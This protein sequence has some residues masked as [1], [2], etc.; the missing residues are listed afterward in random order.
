MN[1]RATNRGGIAPLFVV[2]AEY[3]EA[4]SQHKWSNHSAGYL[5]A[6]IGG[7]EFLLH[8]FV[9]QLKQGTLPPM[10]DHINGVKWDCR[11]G[12]LRP[13]TST[14]NQLNQTQP[15]HKHHHL[16]RGVHLRPR[17][18]NPYF[19]KIMEGGKQKYLGSFS[20]P[21]LASAAYEQARATA[22]TNEARR[23]K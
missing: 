7:K 1:G 6:R 23:S 14:L 17:K 15:K 18:A 20:T 21:E 8:R 9:W 2:D 19:A 10:L 22:I 5:K 3:A 4:V 11:L 13:A 12:N 16:P